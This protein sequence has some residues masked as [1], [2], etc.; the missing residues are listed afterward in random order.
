MEEIDG[1][2]ALIPVPAERT[3]RG[4]FA[5]GHKPVRRK[6]SIMK[7][8]REVAADLK[9]DAIELIIQ[10]V[11]TGAF[12]RSTA[13][14]HRKMLSTAERAKLLIDLLPYIHPKLAATELTGRDGG[15]LASAHLDINALLADP[16]LAEAAQTLAIAIA[17][18]QTQDSELPAIQQ[19]ERMSGI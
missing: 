15:P 4:R 17:E 1:Q 6:P 8:A 9:F 5:P 12:P 14:E 2:K 18:K 7:R 10:L 13:E 11:R 19:P 3:A 16:T